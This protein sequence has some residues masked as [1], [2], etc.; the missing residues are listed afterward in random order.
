MRLS[1]AVFEHIR[2]V[3]IK[4]FMTVIPHTLMMMM[5]P[6]PS[7]GGGDRGAES[8]ERGEEMEGK[9]GGESSARISQQ[10][11]RERER[12]GEREGWKKKMKKVKSDQTLEELG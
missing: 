2:T 7:S 1:A 9:V 6:Q 10:P 5:I 3:S 4:A 11:R 8:T 12:K